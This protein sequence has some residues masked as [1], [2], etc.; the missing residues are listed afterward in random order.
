LAKAGQTEDQSAVFC[1]F[2]AQPQSGLDKQ[3]SALVLNF[4]KIFSIIS[5]CGQ[6]EHYF[7]AFANTWSLAT[8]SNL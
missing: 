2:I 6:T 4:D 5:G 7:P 8:Q 3:R 1:L